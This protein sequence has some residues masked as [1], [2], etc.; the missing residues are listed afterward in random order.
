MIGSK[1]RPLR[2]KPPT[3]AWMRSLAGEPPHVAQDV[4]DAGVPAAGQDDEAASAHPRHERLVVEDQRVGLP[5]AVPM[6]LVP[7]EP[8]FEA[9][10]AVH[11]AGH[12]QRPVEEERRLSLLHDLEARALQGAPARRGE[13]DR[14]PARER[15]TA[16]APEL[17]VDQHGHVR[18]PEPSHQPVHARDVIPVTVAEHDDVDVGG[19]Q[20]QAAHVLHEAVGRPSRVEEDARLPVPL[21]DG[22]ERART[23]ARRAAR[24]RCPRPRG[25]VPRSA[26]R[27]SSRGGAP[28][29]G[30]RAASR[31]RCP[32]AWSP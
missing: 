26:A 3:T 19:R 23:R 27:R 10:A 6:R 8:A 4:D 14:V 22:H 9:R 18:A 31:S 24:R 32:R 30:R 5:R 1:A 13:L 29:A 17:R 12:E 21:G 11:L 2:W 25:G 15:E 20:S 7:G 28:E 16:A